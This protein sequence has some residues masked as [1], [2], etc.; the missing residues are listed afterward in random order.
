MRILVGVDGSDGAAAALGWAA[1][2]AQATGGELVLTTVF[3]PDQAE[4][5][6]GRYEE[7]LQ[8]A[9]RHLG[10]DWSDPVAASEV[11]HR[12][13]LLTGHPDT[14]LEA[15]ERENADLVVVGPR[16]I[17]GFAGL[18]IGSL[19]HH[20]A[21]HTTRPLAIVPSPGAA[22]TFDRLVVGVDGSEGAARAVRWCADLARTT[23]AEVIAVYVFE[24][25]VEWVAESDPRSWRQAAERELRDDWVAPL[26]EAGVRMRT[27]IIEDIH[28]VAGLAAVMKKERAGVAVVG[29]RGGGG[30]H[31]LRLG[32]IP[33][34]LVHHTQRPVVLVPRPATGGVDAAR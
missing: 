16:G 25:L 14:L 26:H 22:P 32:R 30:F 8:S 23:D 7:L 11:P 18:H 12:P 24:P 31:G 34:Q 5:P 15:A 27:R 28:P 29:A 13:L 33:L 19:A 20:L 21:H 4:L 9:R 6:P 3:S 17:G 2:L 1:G 10:A